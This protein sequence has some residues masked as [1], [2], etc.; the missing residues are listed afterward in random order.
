[1]EMLEVTGNPGPQ[2]PWLSH[3]HTRSLARVSGGNTGGAAGWLADVFF[4]AP[5]LLGRMV[6]PGLCGPQLK[7]Q[8]PNYTMGARWGQPGGSCRPGCRL[9]R[10]FPASGPRRPDILQAPK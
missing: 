3:P 9:H 1:M 4:T 6:H 2:A 8:F 5:G 10:Q 7:A